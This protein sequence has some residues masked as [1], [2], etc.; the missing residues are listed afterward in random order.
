MNLNL[1][2]SFTLIG[3]TPIP[4][5]HGYQLY[6]A[7]SNAVPALHEAN[8]LAIHPIAGQQVGDR[9]MMLTPHS[10]LTLRVPD[11]RISEVLPLAGRELKISATKIRIGVPQV[12]ALIPATALRSRLVIIKIKDAPT[13]R[14][15]T[16]ALFESAARRQLD[17][18][19]ISPETQL[20]LGKRRT[21]RIKHNEIVGYEVLIES[22]TAE[23]SLTLQE[24]GMGGRHHMT[25][26]VFVPFET[27]GT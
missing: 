11:G 20:T 13:A 14:D 1:D 21:L 18:L 26:G 12:R 17:K 3:T 10:R 24:S 7:I 6:S 23:E 15:I 2:I 8:G 25:C 9:R 5:D 22:L 19:S 4:A 27:K 16:P